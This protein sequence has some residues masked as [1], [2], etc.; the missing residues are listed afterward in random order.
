MALGT[1][2]DLI[3]QVKS[4]SKRSDLDAQMQDFVTLAETRIRALVRPTMLDEMVPLA[5]VTGSSSVTAP[6]GMLEPIAL[7]LVRDGNW[8]ELNQLQPHDL[9]YTDYPGMPYYFAISGDD[10]VFPAPADAVYDLRLRA[11]PFYSLSPTVQTNSVIQKYPDLYLFATLLEVATWSF[12]AEGVPR[13]DGRFRDAVRRANRQEA[14]A[15]RNVNLITDIPG[16]LR[17]GY[18]IYEGR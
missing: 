17:R 14:R 15:S 2:D 3:A 18:N 4:W 16:S 11:S 1:Y 9:P 10:I 13:W 8:R 5:T 7:W 6:A 12:D